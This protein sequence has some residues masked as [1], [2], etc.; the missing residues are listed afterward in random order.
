MIDN[1]VDV[2]DCIDQGL[3]LILGRLKNNKCTRLG[4]R[5]AVMLA[6][7]V[8]SMLIGGGSIDGHVMFYAG[9]RLVGRILRRT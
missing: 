4:P 9:N 2:I 7:Q 8:H 6:P 3:P 5:K 1:M